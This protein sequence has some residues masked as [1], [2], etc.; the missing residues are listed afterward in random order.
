MYGAEAVI[1]DLSR[2]LT[3]RGHVSLLGVFGA[4]VDEKTEFRW[5]AAEI[6][7]ETH[8]VLCGGQFDTAVPRRIRALVQSTGAD[9]VHAHGYK[10]DVYTLLALRGSAT[11][12]VSTCHTWYDND[13]ALRCYGALDRFVLRRFAAVVAVSREVE[14]SLLSAGVSPARIH[15]IRNGVNTAAFRGADRTRVTSEGAPIIGLVGRL[16]PE[17]GVDIFLKAAAIVRKRMPMV[18]F[19]VA[20]DGPD[21]DRLEALLRDLQLD[22]CAQLLGRQ[23]DMP[24]FLQSLTVL[25]SASR[26][27]GLPI[28]LLEGMASGLPVVATKVG[29]VPRVVQSGETGTLVE[30]E[31][32]EALATAILELLADPPKLARMGEAGRKHVI[33]HFSAERMT[34]DYL[35]VYEKVTQKAA[36]AGTER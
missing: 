26:Q 12:L 4:S 15:V 25:V 17:K 8:T 33:E 24:A 5:R 9:L 19:T 35:S 2:G 34:A 13:L 27:E 11:P 1:L 21:R 7:L 6:D 18:R 36:T 22:G 16:A 10:A 3:Q 31:D 29:E 20:G 23:E 28:A 30:T 32:P 14:R